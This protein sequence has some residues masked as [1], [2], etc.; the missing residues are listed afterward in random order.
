MLYNHAPDYTLLRTF[1]CR[2]YPWLNPY[3]SNKLQPRS[4]HC[5]F[6]GYIPSTKGYRCLDPTTGQI[7]VSRHV[8]FDEDVFPFASSPSVKPAS[9]SLPQLTSFFWS[10]PSADFPVPA[11]SQSHTSAQSQT[12][13][14]ASTQSPQSPNLPQSQISP[15]S[16]SPIVFGHFDSVPATAAPLGSL[17]AVSAPTAGLP[18]SATGL[19]K[20][21]ATLS[22][23]ADLLPSSSISKPPAQPQIP[24]SSLSVLLPPISTSTPIH[25]HTPPNIHT[26]I[27]RSKSLHQCFL[28]SSEYTEPQSYQEASQSSAWTT[29]MKEY[30]TA[31]IKQGTWTLVPLPPN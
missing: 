12:P 1:G 9:P 7:H 15:H 10:A 27:T 3:V 13:S 17:P 4:V 26:M 21:A 19:S 28:T 16:P 25:S 20:S 11:Q 18:Q 29:A 2:C 30:Y 23:S 5:V 22:Q 8:V 24:I 14:P 6:L 31:L